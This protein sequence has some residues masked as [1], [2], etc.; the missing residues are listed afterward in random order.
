VLFYAYMLDLGPFLL[1]PAESQGVPISPCPQY[2]FLNKT[3]TLY[4]F[5]TTICCFAGCLFVGPKVTFFHSSR[6]LGPPSICPQ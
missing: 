5:F 3:S 1:I 4:N 2:H 6:T